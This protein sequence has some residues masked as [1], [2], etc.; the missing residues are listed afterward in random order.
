LKP[1]G[2][3]LVLAQPRLQEVRELVVERIADGAHDL[4][5]A[6][7]LVWALD[8]T[9]LI[10]GVMP[11]VQLMPAFWNAFSSYSMKSEASGLHGRRRP[12]G[13]G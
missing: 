10:I 11:S 7:D 5:E 13:R 4:E 9:R 3:Y 2:G 8:R 1:E 6:F 12:P